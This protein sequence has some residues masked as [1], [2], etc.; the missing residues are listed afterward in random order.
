MRC[1]YKLTETIKGRVDGM[2]KL[3]D[4]LREL[5]GSRS[6]REIEKHTGISHTY[7]ST[8]EKGVDPRRKVT[9]KD[10]SE[11]LGVSEST[12]RMWELGKNKPSPDVLRKLAH[13]YQV[14]YV[15]LLMRAGYITLEDIVLFM[16]QEYDRQ[17]KK[18]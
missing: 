5:R 13:F 17:L 6:L 15:D 10:V 8:I 4:F 1:L 2:S 9:Q 7:L 14:E 12:V 18:E 11:N 16:Q 3:G